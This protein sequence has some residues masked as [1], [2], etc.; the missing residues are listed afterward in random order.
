[1]NKRGVLIAGVPYPFSPTPFL[2]LFLPIPFPRLLRRLVFWFF[3]VENR[4]VNIS[5]FYRV[6]LNSR[7]HDIWSTE[8]GYFVWL[9]ARKCEKQRS[10]ELFNHYST[11]WNSCQNC[12]AN[13]FAVVS[14]MSVSNGQRD[15]TLKLFPS[16]ES[17]L[18]T[19]EASKNSILRKKLPA[20]FV[21]SLP[22]QQA[23]YKLT[24][25]IKISVQILLSFG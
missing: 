7:L 1:M 20:E 10:I 17:T 8:P 6:D 4:W 5:V 12:K 3:H 13:N 2:F 14:K 16:S 21:L 11:E 23:M 9:R 24:Q 19:S 22:S 15:Q 25:K 18:S